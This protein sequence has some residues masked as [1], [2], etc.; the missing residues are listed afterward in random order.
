VRITP[1]K[2]AFFLL[3][4]AVVLWVAGYANGGSSC[5]VVYKTQTV[6]G[7]SL[8][9]YIESGSKVRV[10]FG[11][12]ACAAVVRGD[13][14]IYNDA[15]NGNGVIKIAQAV[16]GDTF[17][18]A[19]AEGGVKI[20]VNGKVLKTSTGEPY[21]LSEDVSRLLAAYERDYHGVIPKRAVLLLGN[22]AG[23]SRDSTRFGLVSTDDILGKVVKVY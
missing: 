1:L 11:Y 3:F 23:G 10:A 18:L 17:A 9:G 13:L 20:V 4:I 14:V 19:L 2:V 8:A 5:P 15:G 7:G 16:G 6:N 22:L 21:R 12:Y